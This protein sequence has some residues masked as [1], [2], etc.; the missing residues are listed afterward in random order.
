MKLPYYVDVHGM[1]L[2][3][4]VQVMVWATIIAYLTRTHAYLDW[5]GV[6]CFIKPK[7]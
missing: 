5:Y 7:E 4:Q 3:E 1:P 2:E 6:V